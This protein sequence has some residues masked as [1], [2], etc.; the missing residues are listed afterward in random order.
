M[1]A[2]LSAT[3]CAL[4]CF[5][6][7]TRG[8]AQASVVLEPVVTSGL[9]SPL[10]LTHPRDGSG[11]LFIVEQGGLIKVLQPGATTPTV[12]LDIRTKVLGGGEQGLLGLAFHPQFPANRRFFVNY[13]RQ[14]DGA[15]VIGEYLASSAD[16]NVADPTET[17]ILVV[18]QPFANHNGGMTEFGPD[19]FLYIALGDGGSANDPGDRAQNVNELLGKILRIDIDNPSGPLNYSAPPSN[20][21]V[22]TA[23]RDEIYALGLR[24]PWRFSFDRS[25]GELYAGDVGQSAREEV[26]KIVSGGNYGWRAFEGTLCT[27]NQPAS[28]CQAPPFVHIPPIAEYDHSGGRCSIT[29]GYVYRGP[30]GTLSPGTYVFADFCSGEIFTYEGGTVTLLMDTPYSI[31][32]FGEDA[33]GEIYVVGLGG[34]VHRLASSTPPCSYAISPSGQSFPAA[35]G[36]GSVAVTAGAGCA[37]A[38]TSAANRIAITSGASGSGDGMVAYA[39]SANTSTAPRTGTLTIAGQ[40]HTVTQAGAPACT[41][42]VSAAPRSFS[43]AGWT[44]AASVTAADGCAW[45]AVSNVPWI[46]ITSG[47]SGIGN[48]SVGY[49]VSPN[50]GRPRSGTMTI[51]GQT[52]SIKQRKR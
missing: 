49:S 26:D 21:F 28:V 24:N 40:T 12:F 3:L 33:Q 48:G 27:T 15:T 52:I 38:A 20:P 5:A 51:A 31:A 36:N 1:L 6:G 4:L 46:T 30:R 47:A 22:G 34:T 19:G 13:T 17:V 25:T 35:G 2:R 16:P 43:A 18:P 37:W 39:V 32:S 41:Y 10:Y 9:S 29:G 42:G 11:R 50:N 7:G 45:A 8:S 44:G 14:T 23:G